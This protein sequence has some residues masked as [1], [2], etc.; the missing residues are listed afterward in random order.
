M[1]RASTT[2]GRRSTQIL[3]G[4][5][6]IHN[7]PLTKR[8]GFRT[9]LAEANLDRGKLLVLRMNLFRANFA[10]ATNLTQNQIE[11]AKGN[12]LFQWS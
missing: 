12:E 11:L 2:R 7:S 1:N 5:V 3:E 8:P 6:A 4:P 9:N 10:E